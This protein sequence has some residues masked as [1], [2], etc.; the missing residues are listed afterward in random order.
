V[1]EI[2]GV[3]YL[4]RAP[5]NLPR[6]FPAQLCEQLSWQP[7]ELKIFIDT[8]PLVPVAGQTADRRS[9]THD[10][11][12]RFCTLLLMGLDG[13]TEDILRPAMQTGKLLFLV[14]S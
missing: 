2:R 8:E 1:A 7:P 12:I 14:S 5:L 3:R 9:T 10:L 11:W 6:R 13:T 4:Q